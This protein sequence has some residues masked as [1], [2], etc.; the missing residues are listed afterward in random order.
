MANLA[1]LFLLGGVAFIAAKS[2]ARKKKRRLEV[3]S[4]D[5]VITPKPLP[6]P[7][8]TPKV[9]SNWA[10][11][12][13]ALKFLGDN[14]ICECDPGDIDG[15]YGGA[16]KGAVEAFQRYAGIDVDGKWGEQTEKAMLATLR[17][18]EKEG[19]PTP[20]PAPLP[21]DKEWTPDDIIVMD[22]DCDQ[23]LHIADELFKIQRRRAAQYALEGDTTYK[24]AESIHQEMV[25]EYAPLCASLGREGVGSG[26]RLWWD[27]NTKWIHNVLREYEILPDALEEDAQSYGL[28]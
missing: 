10:Q 8:P 7:S 27:E 15:K 24:D 12:Q 26:V 9:V 28:S 4:E 11:R 22:A 6:A 13:E 3:V 14:G 16:T 23:M 1:P 5:E 18:L 20:R 17:K 21:S 19:L 25:E 2:A